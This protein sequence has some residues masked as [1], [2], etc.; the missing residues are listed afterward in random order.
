MKYLKDK[1]SK[2]D[3]GDT[4]L[5]LASKQGHFEV[6]KVIMKQVTDKNPK[7]ESGDTP[8]H[9]AAYFGHLRLIKFLMEHAINKNPKNNHGDAPLHFTALGDPQQLG[10]IKST[11]KKLEICQLIIDNVADIYP[12][13]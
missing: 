11:D 12:V 7:G 5:H 13:N 2:S 4:P 3:H 9:Y 1:N 10:S 8:L 6:C